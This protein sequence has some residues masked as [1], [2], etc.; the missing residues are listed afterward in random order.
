MSKG[1]EA[2]KEKPDQQ[3][4][5]LMAALRDPEKCRV[6]RKNRASLLE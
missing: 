4:I 5:R 2:P 6:K 3:V 1:E